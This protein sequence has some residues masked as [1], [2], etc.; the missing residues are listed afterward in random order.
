MVGDA[1]PSPAAVHSW[2]SIC[3][4]TSFWSYSFI[5][6]IH[7]LQRTQ[8]CWRPIYAGACQE[9]QNE[10]SP[11]VCKNSFKFV[12]KLLVLFCAFVQTCCKAI[13]VVVFRLNCWKTIGFIQFSLKHVEKQLV[14]HCFRSILLKT[15]GLVVFSLK[16]AEE[17][18]VLQP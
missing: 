8:V 13:G 6:I 11:Y 1:P 12:E 18:M 3:R 4:A 10:N 7:I 2:L 5:P 17:S 15:V 14:L 9:K 16:H